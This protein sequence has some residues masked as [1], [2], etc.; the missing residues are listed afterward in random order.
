MSPKPLSGIKV[1]DLSENL[2]GP[3]ATLWL[4]SLGADVVKIERPEGDPARRLRKLYR[5]LN[6]NKRVVEVD[7]KEKSGVEEVRG[8]I[9]EADVVLE[10]FRPNT[11]RELGLDFEAL[12]A[13]QPRLI[14]C[15]ITG[16]GQR[17]P[18]ARRPA[19]DLNAQ[20]LTGYA[21][22]ERKNNK[23]PGRTVLPVADLSA[24][25]LAVVRILSALIQRE[26]TGEGEVIDVAMIDL[27]HQWVRLWSDGTHPAEWQ[28]TAN[29]TGKIERWVLGSFERLR[30]Y[31][32]PHY[33]FYRAKNGQVALGIVTETKFWRRLVDEAGRPFL[34]DFSVPMRAVS[35]QL[36][37]Q[38]LSRRFG[39]KTVDEW[40]ALLADVLPLSPVLTVEDAR[41]H[42]AIKARGLQDEVA[43]GAP[44]ED[45]ASEQDKLL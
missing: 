8:L 43:V 1:V 21:H 28:K 34:K 19:H 32:L 22:L 20:A 30:L 25:V 29:R 40:V 5:T 27:L 42:E 7:L 3:Y 17:G 39:R 13:R 23:N 9:L 35:S 2:P 18:W 45:R 24:A 41:N 16:Y 33:G 6:R 31:A 36:V 14:C 38:V 12:R 4:A 15:S 10:S 44:V 11:L 26:R 37:R